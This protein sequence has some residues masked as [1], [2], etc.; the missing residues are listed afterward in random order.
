MEPYTDLAASYDYI[1]GHVNYDEWYR[2]L[3]TLMCQY[4]ENP[5]LILEL[6]CGTGK[7]G[8]KFSRDDFPIYG[9]DKSIEMLS[10]AKARAFKDFHIFCG[11]MMNFHLTKKFDF[12]FSVHD[13]MN[14][15]L[16]YT[17]LRKVFKSVRRVVRDDGVF[18]FDVTTEYNIQRFFNNKRMQYRFR[19]TDIV[20]TNTYNPKARIVVSTLTFTKRGITSVE[21]HYQRI[22]SVREIRD[23]L[24]KEKFKVID[25]FGDYTFSPP[26][27]DTVMINFITRK[28]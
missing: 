4:I 1:L 18:M 16:R 8:A 28:L 26:T 24:E 27:S 3:R 13:T 2:Y 6:G 5:R 11:D 17:D 9:M 14:Y 21:H 15:F 22:Y 10:V 20:W 23:L 12:V 25:I 19:G 7:F